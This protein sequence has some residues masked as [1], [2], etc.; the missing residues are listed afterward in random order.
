MRQRRLEPA[1]RPASAAHRAVLRG[2]DLSRVLDSE[3]RSVSRGLRALLPGHTRVLRDVRG[4]F[5]SAART[6][7]NCSTP[8]CLA[9]VD[10]RVFVV[11]WWV[12]LTGYDLPAAFFESLSDRLERDF[13]F[14]ALLERPRMAV[15]RR[16]GRREL[17]VQRFGARG[18]GAQHEAPVGGS[19]GGLLAAEPRRLPARSSSRPATGRA[20]RRRLGRCDRRAPAAVNRARRVV[21]RGHGRQPPDAVVARQSC[22]R[23][24]PLER[25]AGRGALRHAA[26]SSAGVHRHVG[27]GEPVALPGF[28][29]PQDPR[30]ARGAAAGGRGP[31]CSP[32]PDSRATNGRGGLGRDARQ[33]RRRR[34][35]GG[36]R[37]AALP[38]RL[39]VTHQ[40]RLHRSPAEDLGPRRRPARLQGRSHRPG[41]QR[42]CRHRA[43]RRA[44]RATAEAREP[45]SRRSPASGVSGTPPR[46]P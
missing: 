27:S 21:Q 9:K 32:R 29:P 44:E 41:R 20:V 42:R 15:P 12:P 34:R 36:A 33:G 39:A 23:R 46:I 40:H 17:P 19:A 37:S 8:N 24:Q 35:Q 31:D 18:V 5:P 4:V 11:L 16:A 45:G 7:G 43:I 14:R 1:W 13:G 2:R 38:G 30:M 3:G 28:E 6:E 25:A 22:A 10:G 26:V